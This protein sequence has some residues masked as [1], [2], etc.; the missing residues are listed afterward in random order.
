LTALFWCML[1]FVAIKKLFGRF[2]VNSEAALLLICIVL[3]MSSKMLPFDVLAMRQGM[4][5]IGWFALG[6]F[7]EKLRKEY[8]SVWSSK[9]KIVLCLV[10]GSLFVLNIKIG[11]FED[12]MNVVCGCMFAYFTAETCTLLFRRLETT[13]CYRVMMRNLFAVYLFH[14]PLEYIIL[15]VFLTSTLLATAWGCY[16]YLFL[17]ILGVMI[18]SIVI[19]EVLRFFKKSVLRRKKEIAE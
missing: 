14:D 8:V 7:F 18:V 1:V 13:A 16:L 5:Y 6:Y 2:H 11:I 4:E 3:Q 19:G 15:K 10:T 17:R 9:Y 12:I